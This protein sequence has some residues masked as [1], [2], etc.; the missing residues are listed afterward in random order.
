MNPIR[1]LLV[2]LLAWVSFGGA[3]A[4]QDLRPQYL[5]T[6]ADSRDAQS[7]DGQWTYSKDLYKQG[8]SDINGWVAKSRMQ[9]YRD[10][11]VAAEEAKGGIEFYEFDMERGPLMTIPGAWNAA[12]PQL[13]YYDGLIWFQR[14]FTPRPMPGGRSFLRFEAVNYRAYVYLNG[15]EIGRHEG[16]FTPFVLEI[17]EALRAGEN[18]L[19]VGVDS[20]HDAQSI[21]T[22]IT[23][24][25]L[26]GGITRP[27][28]LIH[29]P[30]TFIDDAML[31]LGTDGRITGEVVLKGPN[32]A[33]QTVTAA[34]GDL[35]RFTATT[36][37]SG[38][39]AFSFAKPISPPPH[40]WPKY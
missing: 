4:A 17:T 20:A 8:L 38:R 12:E 9:R 25:D 10:I 30:Q 26:Y 21:P 40:A 33:G 27:V 23:D 37:A 5:L 15:K 24:W 29:T 14:K 36:D 32:A 2:M 31:S 35:G 19:T 22:T 16:G 18:R 1:L 39:A 7:L 3:A 6:G 28:T 34:I 11:D 13:R